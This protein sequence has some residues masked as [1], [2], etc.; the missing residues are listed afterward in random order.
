MGICSHAK[1]IICS[2]KICDVPVYVE[3]NKPNV[4]QNINDNSA[5]IENNITINKNINNNNCNNIQNTNNNNHDSNETA[6]KPEEQNKEGQKRKSILIKEEN[7]TENINIQSIDENKDEKQDLK[8]KIRNKKKVAFF[9]TKEIDSEDK[10]EE[11]T[12]N[13]K[14][15]HSI[16]SLSKKVIKFNAMESEENSKENVPNFRRNKKKAITLIDK[17]FHLP[18]K[19]RGVEMR[20]PVIQETLVTQ[21]FGDPDKYYKKLKDLGSGSY[22]SVYQAKNIIMDNIVAIK[23]IEKVEYNM[24]ED[25]EIKNEINIL[26]TLSHPNIVKKE[27][28]FLI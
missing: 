21:K 24:V 1:E 11:K 22:G 20:I 16:M 10:G 12:K 23:V 6:Q 7:K 19:L 27:N 2:S 13:R 9:S 17:S 8:T 5:N 15:G 18:E 26:K 4:T 14:R 28:Y 25:L 3:D